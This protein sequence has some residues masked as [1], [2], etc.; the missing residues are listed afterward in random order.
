MAVKAL[1]A[2]R[3]QAAR[4]RERHLH[5]VLERQRRVQPADDVHLGRPVGVALHG[6]LD[7]LVGRQD[8]RIL[9]PARWACGRTRRTCTAAR[10]RWCS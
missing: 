8:V 7:D 9:G 2:I 3:G 6:L 4:I 5:V 1:I 10:R